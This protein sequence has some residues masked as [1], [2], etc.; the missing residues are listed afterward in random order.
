[1]RWGFAIALLGISAAASACTET[2][3]YVATPASPSTYTATSNVDV[4]TP[5]RR[6]VTVTIDKSIGRDCEIVAVF[7]VH[8]HAES[9]DKGFEELRARAEALGAD[10][11]IGA[12]FEHG[13]GGEPSHLSG[14][15]V[16][17]SA[18]RPAYDPLGEIDIPSNED[19]T[20][21]GLDAMKAKAAAMGADEVVNVQ[22]EHGEDGQL[23]HLTGIAVK[24]RR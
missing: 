16:K 23:G 14:M 17:F 6:H 22:F 3:S 2:S 11:V 10:A 19:D 13:D 8:T 15:A 18:P 4:P 7:D 9:Q 21:K 20:D 12:E 1:M 5:P 24:Y